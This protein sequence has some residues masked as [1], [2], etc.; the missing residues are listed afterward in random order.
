MHKPT[1][2]SIILFIASSDNSRAV[3]KNGAE[4]CPVLYSLIPN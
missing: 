4:A 3:E 1:F 2:L